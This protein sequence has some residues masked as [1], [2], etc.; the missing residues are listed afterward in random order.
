MFCPAM[1]GIVEVGSIGNQGSLRSLQ[2]FSQMMTLVCHIPK[3][4]LLAKNLPSLCLEVCL[5][6]CKLTHHA[7]QH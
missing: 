1:L 6:V 7:V 2:R 4:L 3:K 5:Q